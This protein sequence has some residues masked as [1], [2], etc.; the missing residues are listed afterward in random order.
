MAETTQDQPV[1]QSLSD[2][3]ADLKGFGIED[4][5]EPIKLTSGSKTVLIKLSNIPSEEE[6][7]ALLAVEEFKGY[8]WLQKV[9]AEILSRDQLDQ[10]S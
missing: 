4:F 7:V 10:W 9:K 1:P 3:L 5:Q 2:V 6:N 8:T